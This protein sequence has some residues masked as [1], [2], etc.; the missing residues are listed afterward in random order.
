MEFK[1]ADQSLILLDEDQEYLTWLERNLS[2]EDAPLFGGRH[3]V[4]ADDAFWQ[5]W[6]NHRFAPGM[7]RSNWSNRPPRIKINSLWWPS[8]A[9]R[10]AVAP[11]KAAS[12]QYSRA[13]R[14]RA[15]AFAPS[16]WISRIRP[17]A[18]GSGSS[19]R[20]PASMR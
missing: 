10:W 5:P 6:S 20:R 9:S 17:A 18:A 7:P 15:G 14:T 1:Y 13:V 2:L 8:G 4:A 19:S 11:S 12:S 16:I 3:L